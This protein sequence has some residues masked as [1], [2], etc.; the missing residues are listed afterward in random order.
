MSPLRNYYSRVN[1]GLPYST[2]RSFGHRYGYHHSRHYHRRSIYHSRRRHRGRQQYAVRGIVANTQGQGNNG[3]VQ[4][5]VLPLS[6]T[7]FRYFKPKNGGQQLPLQNYRVNNNTRFQVEF[8]NQGAM[9]NGAFNKLA[10]GDPVIILTRQ[11]PYR[12][13]NANNA[14]N[15]VKA[16]NNNGVAIGTAEVIEVFQKKNKVALGP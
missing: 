15:N 2:G 14:N 4:I 1:Y 9:K 3:T 11:N 5:R 13:V 8:G 7:N 6:D 12:Q 10:Q 16:N